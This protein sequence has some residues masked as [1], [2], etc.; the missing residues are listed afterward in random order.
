MRKHIVRI[1]PPLSVQVAFLLIWHIV[2]ILEVFPP[3]FLTPPLTV[4]QAIRDLAMSGDLWIHMGWSLAR[5]GIGLLT[6]G[7]IG[8]VIGAAC[9]LSKRADR[10][11]GPLFNALKQVPVYAWAPMMI[12]IFGIGEMSKVA[13]VATACF[14]P[15]LLSTQQGIRSVQEK[16]LEIARIFRLSRS[17]TL[18]RI[19]LP[20][21]LPAICVGVRQ[22]FALAWMAVVGAELMGAES[23][24]GYLM[25]QARML[26]Q[27]DVILAGV[28]LVGTVGILINGILELFE[29]K[30]FF[31]SGTI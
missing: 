23:G 5:V 21:S 24:I 12:I 13:F 30:L 16:H 2:A 14:Y 27:M 28:F 9:G 11:V 31:W 7:L 29:K 3:T 25:T 4:L 1:L 8:F 19:V 6:G 10:W 20:S 15:T 26:F 22:A 17:E 18:R